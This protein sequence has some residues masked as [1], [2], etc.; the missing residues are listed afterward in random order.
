MTNTGEDEYEYEEVPAN[1]SSIQPQTQPVAPANPPAK[2]SDPPPPD[3]QQQSQKSAPIPSKPDPVPQ[4]YNTTFVEEKRDEPPLFS[5]LRVHLVLKGIH[6]SKGV[7][8]MKELI[9]GEYERRYGVNAVNVY[10]RRHVDSSATVYVG[11]RYD[12]EAYKVISA[13]NTLELPL[14]EKKGDRGTPVYEITDLFNYLLSKMRAVLQEQAKKY[15]YRESRRADDRLRVPRGSPHHDYYSGREYPPP[16]TGPR[17]RE[18]PYHHMHSRSRSRS[19]NHS[20]SRSPAAHDPAHHSHRER[21][22]GRR[23]NNNNPSGSLPPRER[24]GRGEHSRSRS[25]SRSQERRSREQL[26]SRGHSC[27]HSRSGSRD[28]AEYVRAPRRYEEYSPKEPATYEPHQY[29]PLPPPPL[30]PRTAPRYEKDPVYSSS[31]TTTRRRSSRSRSNEPRPMREFRPDPP[32]ILAKHHHEYPAVVV[33]DR[34]RP[35]SHYAREPTYHRQPSPQ[36]A[37]LPPYQS[38]AVSSRA[39]PQPEEGEIVTKEGTQRPGEAKTCSI[40]GVPLKAEDTDIKR[41]FGKR[42]IPWPSH[43]NF[44]SKSINFFHTPD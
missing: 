31:S 12:Y 10:I 4:K 23:S 40:L 32:D 9:A 33:D 27:S 44:I 36:A 7:E 41:E 20:R 35:S 1:Q 24:E 22:V 25:R 30:P 14:A 26:R 38:A 17:P 18:V 21:S 39:P 3:S 13:P 43:C 28:R 8:A 5:Q 19:Q 16:P 37:P 42:G 15:Y 2:S 34:D 6:A 29:A 11:F